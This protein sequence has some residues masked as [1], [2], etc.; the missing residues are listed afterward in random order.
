MDLRHGAVDPPTSTHLSPV[1]DELLRGGRQGHGVL[2]VL[3]VKT[4][5]SEI[6]YPCQWVFTAA[7][8]CKARR[9]SFQSARTE[10]AIF[11]AAWHSQWLWRRPRCFRMLGTSLGEPQWMLAVSKP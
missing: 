2:P 5:I 8:Y 7:L 1:E 3:S 9:H 10:S 6:R 11:S 4:E